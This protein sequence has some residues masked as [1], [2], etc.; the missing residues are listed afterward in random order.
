MIVSIVSLDLPSV[1]EQ[2]ENDPELFFKKYTGCLL[3]DEIQYAPKLFRQILKV[4]ILR[5]FERFLDDGN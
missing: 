3:V 5:A 1:A 2:A 4:S